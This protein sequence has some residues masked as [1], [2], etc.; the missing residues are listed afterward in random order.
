[1]SP[2]PQFAPGL[3][4]GTHT[5][6]AP[7]N[8]DQG[9]GKQLQR[10]EYK[11]NP[12]E[13]GGAGK[14]HLISPKSHKEQKPTQGHR[15]LYTNGAN[16]SPQTYKQLLVTNPNTGQGWPSCTPWSDTE[17]LGDSVYL[18]HTRKRSFSEA[19]SLQACLPG[20][21]P[22]WT[23]TRLHLH[24]IHYNCLHRVRRQRPGHCPL[25]ARD[26]R[27]LAEGHKKLLLLCS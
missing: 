19:S 16:P 15:L 5:Y 25:L 13:H 11:S 21:H 20:S 2:K 22:R 17:P 1:M 4:T 24:P 9:C 10:E 3:L 27:C 8:S 26:H 6:G 12:A 23:L 18:P 14:E 7:T